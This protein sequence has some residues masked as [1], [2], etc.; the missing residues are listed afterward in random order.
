[1]TPQSVMNVCEELEIFN[2]NMH[3]KCELQEATQAKRSH[4]E[5]NIPT[6]KQVESDEQKASNCEQKATDDVKYKETENA[7]ECVKLYMSS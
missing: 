7:Q 4:T 2:E 3:D 1:M 5:L 6:R